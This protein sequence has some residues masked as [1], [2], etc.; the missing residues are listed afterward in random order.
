MEPDDGRTPL[1]NYINNSRRQVLTE[2]YLLSD[3]DIINALSLVPSRGATISAILEE[4][5]FGGNNLNQKTNLTLENAAVATEWS[6]P[7]Y[8]L[9]HEK[10]MIFDDQVVCVLNMNLTKTA[11][12]RNREYN[13]CS[14]NPVDVA[15]AEK[16]FQADWQK[17]DYQPADSNLVIS[18]N[19][20]RGKLTALINSAARTLDIE[21][22]VIGDR[23]ILELLS[24]RSQSISVRVIEPEKKS[25][26]NPPIPGVPVRILTSPYPHA[27]LIIADSERAYT[28]S[29]NLSTQSLDQ[30]R[31][32]G[33]LVSQPDILERLNATFTRDWSLAQP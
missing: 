22:E 17:T 29:I 32:L 5:P 15:E 11:F 23:Q 9:T 31:E 16:V 13:I 26:N 2:I 14:V 24:K 8:A 33:I 7:A 19:N 30:N 6:N 12:T 18:P 3:P 21:M 1:L 28:G 20:S 10:A 25:V 4:H 27:K